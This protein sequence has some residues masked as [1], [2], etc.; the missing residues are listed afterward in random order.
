MNKLYNLLLATAFLLSPISHYAQQTATA[1]PSLST[2]NL[3]TISAQTPV[4]A[5]KEMTLLMAK[6]RQINVVEEANK[7]NT[8][9]DANVEVTSK[10]LTQSS[11]SGL[12][13]RLY[14]E[15]TTSFLTKDL[16]NLT[17]AKYLSADAARNRIQA[18]LGT[19]KSAGCFAKDDLKKQTYVSTKTAE[20]FEVMAFS[21]D[22]LRR[23]SRYGMVEN[24]KN[25]YARIRKDQV[26]GF[27]NLCG[28]EFITPQ[29]EKAEP[30]NNGKAIAKR[31][32]W[33]FINQ[34]G[35]ESEPL[36]RLTEAKALTNGI[37][38][39]KLSNLKQA[40]ID[41]SFDQSKT[42]LSQLYD[43]I[44]PFYKNSV[45][46]IRQGKK[47]GLMGL[48]GKEIL[49][50]VYDDIDTTNTEGVYKL[51]QGTLMGLMDT[52]WTIKVPIIIQSMSAFNR[53]GY[54]ILI[55]EKG[56]TIMDR[57]GFKLSSYYAGIGEF[58]RF[59]LSVIRSGE[60]L[61]GLMDSTMK[62]II[63][64]KY[65]SV[66]DF[67]SMGLAAACYPGNK[68]GF[69]NAS[70]KEQIKPDYES[71]GNFNNFGLAVVQTRVPDC[72]KAG[73]TPC[74]GDIVI[75]QEGSVVVPVT[76]E[77][78]SR[79][80]R[81]T[82]TDSL[83]SDNF[84][85]LKGTSSDGNFNMLIN[86]STFKLIT[87]SPYS[88]IT[89]LDVL[90]NFRVRSGDTWGLID[91]TGKILLK[92]T[93]KEIVRQ[94]EEY[95]ATQNT[96]NKWGFLNKKGRPQIPF[97]YEEVASYRNG[98]ATV[99]KGKGK[100]GIINRFNGKIAPCAFKTIDI[101]EKTTDFEIRDAENILILMDKD[102]NCKTNCPK[103]ESY[104]AKANKEE[105][106]P[107]KK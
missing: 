95:Y 5:R 94:S 7:S 28:E 25:G 70:G 103:L 54:S 99:S 11:N 14:L 62:V 1:I 55:T 8:F 39:V 102:G 73:G 105:G 58:N 15:K 85:I 90:G 13:Y 83:F 18:G 49:S 104:R 82:L 42:Y 37:T 79:N 97:E 50:A 78:A 2:N 60:N 96:L 61:Y 33:F 20:G 69:I 30:F 26:Y 24:Y 16:E 27:M 74:I 64:P 107:A 76:N 68:C 80:Y 98:F 38:L 22:S 57:D 93:Y 43:G 91:S 3:P 66:G 48:N 89:P 71:V 6:L 21:L 65:A 35:E 75:D 44:E 45:F 41:N 67:N 77:S 23:N 17:N 9:S 34:E 52:S 88:T 31:V 47:V 46:K 59:G 86:R 29:Y 106:I 63:T 32:D 53:F 10:G 87:P 12:E 84:I 56:Q 4:E 100:W 19:L 36:E 81:Y 72:G 101:N 92:P 40:F 51:T